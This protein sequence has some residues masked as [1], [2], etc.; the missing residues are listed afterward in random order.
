MAVFSSVGSGIL[1]DPWQRTP[2]ACH[3]WQHATTLA[4]FNGLLRVG[5]HKLAYDMV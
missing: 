3:H 5:M 2:P 4:N 1:K